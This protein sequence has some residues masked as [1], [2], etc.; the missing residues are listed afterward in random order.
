MKKIIILL[1]IVGLSACNNKAEQSENQ[2]D[3][4]EVNAEEHN[5]QKTHKHKHQHAHSANDYMHQSSTEELIERFESKAR[6]EYQQPEKVLDYLG[7]LSGKTIMDIGSGS[8]YF[9]VK[10]AKK[11][12]KVIAADVDQTFLDYIQNR[13]EKDEINNIELRKIP[14]DSPALKSREVDMVFIVNTYHHIENREAYFGKVKEGLKTDG[15]LVIIDFFKKE[16]PVGPPADHK[17]A[18]DQVLE[19][20]KKTGFTSFEVNDELLPYQFIIKA[21]G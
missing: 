14:Y 7:D 19:E 2:N 6:D 4:K 21:K 20:L 17:I 13:I 8:G 3:S 9:S 16:I 5:H 12:Q 1:L 10:L 18:K 15:E 11:A